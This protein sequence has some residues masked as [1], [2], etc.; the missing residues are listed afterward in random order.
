[1]LGIIV[2][3]LLL[4]QFSAFSLVRSVLNDDTPTPTV[5]LYVEIIKFC[6]SIVCAKNIRTN[7]FKRPLAIF[8]PTICFVCMNIVSY[9]VIAHISATTYVMMMQ[10]K[11]PMTCI[12]SFIVLKSRYSWNQLFCIFLICLSCVNIC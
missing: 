8:V 12:V 6:I 2:S 4:I 10:L 5:L 1:M 3:V 9:G 7:I 11:I